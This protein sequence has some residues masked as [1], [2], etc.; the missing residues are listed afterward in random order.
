VRRVF[1]MENCEDLL[2]VWLRFI[3][4]VVDSEDL[5]LNVSRETLQDN[6]IIRVMQKQVVNHCLS[7]LEEL[8][9]QRPDDYVNC[10]KA[11]GA[12]LKEGLHFA[13]EH[14]VRLA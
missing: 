6:K 13:P 2:P 12:V 14:S 5:P 8:A 9:E 7:M 4:G 10:W 3:R 1:V 11:F